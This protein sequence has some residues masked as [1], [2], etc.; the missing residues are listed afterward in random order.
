MAVGVDGGYNEPDMEIVLY[1]VNY[2]DCP[3]E[4]REKVS[5]SGEQ[6][7]ELMRCLLEQQGI[8]EAAILQTCNRTELY[9][10]AKKDVEWKQPVNEVIS[11]FG[12]EIGQTWGRYSKQ[13]RGISAARH[14]FAVAAGLDSQMLGENQIL[15]QVKAAYLSSI[16]CRASRFVFHRLFHTA[17]RA[18]KQVRTETNINCGAVSISLAAVELAKEKMNFWSSAALVIGAGENAELAARYLVKGGIGS[19]IVANR[20]RDKAEEMCKRLDAGEIIGLDEIPGRLSEVALVISSTGADKPVVT[21][22]KVKDALRG[23]NKALLMI[24][25][26]VPRDIDET[27]GEIKGVTLVN[28]DDLDKR[29]AVN[30][31]K[32]SSEIP[33][34]E[35]IVNDFAVKFDRWLDTL[36]VV[37]VVTQL[38]QKVSEMA[39]AEAKRYAKDFGIE[40]AEKL[41]MFAE[42]LAKKLLHGPVS[43]IKDADPDESGTASQLMSLDL[44][45]KMF[46][47]DDPP[48]GEASPSASE[49]EE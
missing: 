42:S 2:H 37:P 41:E 35:K 7:Q 28:I 16:E 27:I 21:F 30:R 39:K 38:T 34:A 19:L 48:V 14:L 49:V 1:S 20:S 31:E 17:F 32:R 5:F 25:I 3:V 44:I 46:L 15:S 23:R 36:S 6:Q 24:D 8:S 13:K 12:S 18:G 40:N 43:F 45:N 47:L 22:E 11:R 29:I 9:L 26:A 4:L 33:R 10:Y